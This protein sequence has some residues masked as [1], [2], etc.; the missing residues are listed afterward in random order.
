MINYNI[1]TTDL[2]LMNNIK[3]EK[4]SLVATLNKNIK[5]QL[6]CLD[7]FI[8]GMTECD[9]KELPNTRVIWN[10][11][12]FV[13]IES[14]ELK[15]IQRDLYAST[16]DWE[17]RHYIRQAYLLMHE[18]FRTYHSE[19]KGFHHIIS[20][21]LDVSNLQ[22]EKANVVCLIRDFK[23]KHEKILEEIRHN[24]IAH[25]NGDVSLQVKYIENLNF[26]ESIS[27]MLE[28]DRILNALGA[29]LQKVINAGLN[30]IGL[31]K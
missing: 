29:Y 31:L 12:A 27:I 25:R 4:S 22:N 16:S 13:N 8:K 14:I 26:S 15:T 5:E 19:N 28:F 1:S 11:S 30:D 18:F 7:E 21:K 3:K 10:L 9:K 6:L 23:K 20:E 24:T 17:Q 2:L